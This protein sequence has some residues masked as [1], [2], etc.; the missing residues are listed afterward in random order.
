MRA[1]ITQE[2][3]RGEEEAIM[4]ELRAEAN[5]ME[6]RRRMATDQ[7]LVRVTRTG[8]CYSTTTPS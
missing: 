7:I 1:K 6:Y 8:V 4:D 5:A 2:M 3:R